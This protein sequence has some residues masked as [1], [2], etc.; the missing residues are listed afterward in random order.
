MGAGVSGWPLARAVAET[1]ELGVVAGTALPTIMARRLQTGDIGGHLRRALSAFPLQE[2]AERILGRY[3]SPDGKDGDAPFL[4]HSLPSTTPS[5]SLL[6]LTVVANFAEIFLAKEGH[7]GHVGLNLLEKIQVPTLASIY[8][9]MLAGVDYILMGAGIPRSIPGILDKF[10]KGEPAEMKIDVQGALPGENFVT[11][12]DPANFL[13]QS[14]PVLKRPRFIAIVSSAA[15]ATTLARKSNGTVDGFVVEGPTAGGHNAPPRGPM[16]LTADGQP[17]YGPRDVPEIEKIRALGLPFWLAGSFGRPGKLEEA[18]QL[19]AAGIQV[20]TPFAFCEESGISPE[21]KAVALDDSRNGRTRVHTD[22][23]ASPTGFPFK[24]LQ[25]KGTLGAAD[26]DRQRTK[27]C[28]L[29][30][31]RRAYRRDDGTIGYRC[32]AEPEADFVRKGGDIAETIGRKCVCNGLLATIDLPQIQKD[33]TAEPALVTA[34]DDA[35][36]I[37][38]FLQPGMSTYSARDV[39]ERLR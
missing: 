2:I 15:L 13:G 11:K 9:A 35:S 20:A 27:T 16:Q 31:L 4:L 38:E 12:F 7:K 18:R 36:H 32:P 3:W 14:A 37:H 6:E 26:T 1:G 34:G 21:I 39:V 10:A 8:G 22:P 30:Y 19:G 5:R 29:G 28:D 25:I 24:I 17:V 33:G 23:L